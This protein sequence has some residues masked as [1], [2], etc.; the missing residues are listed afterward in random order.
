M[1]DTIREQIISNGIMTVLAG[2][3]V[4]NGYNTDIGKNVLRAIQPGVDD[5]PVCVAWP[6]DEEVEQVFGKNKCVMPV[7]V[8]G[9]VKRAE[10]GYSGMAYLG[11]TNPSVAAEKILGDLIK[12][13][14][15]PATIASTTNSLGDSV[16]YTGGGPGEYPEPGSELAGAYVNIEISY[17]TLTGNPYAQS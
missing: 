17:K 1:T 11:E 16:K 3:T 6:G 4:A 2:T 5:L 7:R 10:Y 14:T 8:E 12:C 9:I 15:D 13:L